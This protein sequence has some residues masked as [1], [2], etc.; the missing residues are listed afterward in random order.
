MKGSKQIVI[1]DKDMA[2]VG[3]ALRRATKQAS[4]I[5]K[6]SACP[7]PLFFRPGLSQEACHSQA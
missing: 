7:Q 5:A 1:L 4:K 6:R 2:G 3:P